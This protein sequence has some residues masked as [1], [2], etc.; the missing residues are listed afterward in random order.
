MSPLDTNKSRLPAT[1]FLILHKRLRPY[2]EFAAFLTEGKCVIKE[3]TPIGALFVGALNGM[4]PH[5]N[6]PRKV[7]VSSEHVRKKWKS[8]EFGYQLRFLA[9]Y[10]RIFLECFDGNRGDPLYGYGET[11]IGIKD[12]PQFGFNSGAILHDVYHDLVDLSGMMAKDDFDV[13]SPYIV[14]DATHRKRTRFRTSTASTSVYPWKHTRFRKKARNQVYY[15]ISRCS[16]AAPGDLWSCVTKLMKKVD[17][18][19]TTSPAGMSLDEKTDSLTVDTR[20][21][22]SGD[23]LQSCVS[24]TFDQDCHW[25]RCLK[26]DGCFAMLFERIYIRIECVA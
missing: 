25:N 10:D 4:S 9:C 18:A 16:T 15:G 1:V 17:V 5:I 13:W 11:A 12:P 7:F 24:S 19:T 22:H 23:L 6:P 14:H 2:D 3:N 8:L 21:L 20:V 26:V